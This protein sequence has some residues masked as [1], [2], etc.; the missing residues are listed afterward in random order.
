MFERMSRVPFVANC[1]LLAPCPGVLMG[2][3]RQKSLML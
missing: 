3:V 1:L 2:I